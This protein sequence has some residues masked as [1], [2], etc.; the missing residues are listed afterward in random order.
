[1]NWHW[2]SLRTRLVVGVLGATVLSLW[3]VTFFI[4]HTLRQDME[5]AISAQQFSTV[6]LIAREID[7][8]V[9]ERT[10]VLRAV[11]QRVASAGEMPETV[12]GILDEHSALG[13]LFNWGA[14]VVDAQGKALASIPKGLGRAGTDYGQQPFVREALAAND[15]VYGEPVVGKATGV[16]VVPMAVPIRKAD[17]ESIGVLVGSTNL[18]KP[19]FLDEISTSKYGQTGD[20]L[21]TAPKSRVFIASSDKRRV[22]KAG[23]P[24]GVNAVYDRYLG[25]YEGSGVAVSS[26]GVE[27]LSSSRRIPSTGWLMQSVLPTEEAFA[28]IRSMQRHLVLVS[29]LLTLLAG[30]TAWW[31]LRRQL[32]P[33]GEAAGLLDRM[34]AGDLPRQP[35]PVRQN[36]EIGMLANAF[37]GLLKAIEKQ[38]AEAA[39]NAA[40]RQVRKILS[41]VPGMVF[42]YRLH[43]DGSGAFPFASEAVRELYEVEAEELEAEAGKIRA[44]VLPEDKERFFASLHQSRQTL[45]RW[46]VDYR[47]VT[48]SGARKWL[49]VDAVPEMTADGQIT[50]YGFVTDVTATKAMEVELEQHRHHLEELVAERTAELAAAKT[51][52]ET[53]NVAKS[54]FL[55]NM[56]H[57]IR[58]PL[59]AITGMAHLIRRAGATPQQVERLDKIDAAGRHLLDIINAILDLSKIEAGKFTLEET[60]FSVGTLIGNVVSILAEPAEAKGLQ[61]QVEGPPLALT[62]VG[63][64]TR[65]QQAL[66]NYASNAVKFTQRGTV[67]L[68]VRVE[69]ARPE[70]VQL[71]F[72]VRDTGV[73]IAPEA[74]AKLFSAFE[75][76][77]NSITRK[78]GGTGLGLAITRRLAQL[79][80]G[81]AGGSSE[82]GVGSTFWFTVQLRKGRGTSA[83]AATPPTTSY[84]A[85]LDE[86]C[87]GRRVLLVEDE[88]IN[89]EVA[90]EML[91][92]IGLV[93][94]F[95][96]DGVQA[97]EL[98]GQRDY[99]L[100]LMDMQMPN[101]D[102]LEATRRLR[103]AERTRQVPIVAMTANAFA[104][105]R[106][107]CFACGMDDFIAKPVEPEELFAILR[108]WLGKANATSLPGPGS[109]MP[110]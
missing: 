97:L 45:R 69:E 63:D 34:R 20:F 109:G 15:V 55:A 17:G 12:Q 102:G 23:P 60:E 25:G 92:D 54:T 108:K 91:A 48:P 77:D 80:G 14:F 13:V 50:W 8:S 95:A 58:T 82:L 29:L 32:Q 28:P 47:I 7:R 18:E 88:M 99:D 39:E 106:E 35:L 110:S 59:N 98:A 71:R 70:H 89:R 22:M 19:N 51:A 40:N 4:S 66:L 93:A 11:A 94:D 64:A 84:A 103:Q 24:P 83:A 16:A 3:V 33:L 90:L 49:R 76:A 38:E 96:E 65:L 10:D 26:R 75:Q 85:T 56:S 57:E 31:W 100:I 52:A 36:D 30:G 86:V 61:L 53:A 5:A 87:R 78:Y 21:L 62:V 81:D 73:G 46:L 101:M 42:Q 2:Q 41:H 37:N 79:M 27:E 44:M 1:M 105:D 68:G 67:T 43:A 104:E 72:E 6:S 74:M 107:R 9:R